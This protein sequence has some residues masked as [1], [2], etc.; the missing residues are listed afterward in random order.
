MFSSSHFGS[1]N[2]DGMNFNNATISTG[3]SLMKFQGIKTLSMNDLSLENVN[4]ESIDNYWIQISGSQTA[5]SINK[6]N[7]TKIALYDSPA[8]AMNNQ[9][10]SI[11]MSE[12]YFDNVTV[13]S[14][15]SIIQF[16]YLS[17][18]DMNNVT[19]SNIVSQSTESSNNY[20]IRIVQTGKS[21]NS[22]KITKKIFNYFIIS[23]LS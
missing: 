18:L 23:S 19:F 20:M 16:S 17:A 2:I 6:I 3:L 5:L 12:L 1:V 22:K 7:A 21:L 9:F 14:D 11:S 8:F 10:S 15:N 4:L 13:A